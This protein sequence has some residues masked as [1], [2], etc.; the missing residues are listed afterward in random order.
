MKFIPIA[1]GRNAGFNKDAADVLLAIGVV[2]AVAVALA[3]PKHATFMPLS[4]LS[5][6][7]IFEENIVATRN[8]PIANFLILFLSS[9]MIYM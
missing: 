8:E 3:I 2:M 6:A 1:V 7:C 4:S 5:L 9:F